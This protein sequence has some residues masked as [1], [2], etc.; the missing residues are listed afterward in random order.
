MIQTYNKNCLE[1]LNHMEDKSVDLIVTDP[2]YDIETRGGGI[3]KGK[4]Q[5][6]YNTITPIASGYDSRIIPELVRVLK[7][8]NLYIFCSHAQLLPTIDTFV[9]KYG[10]KYTLISWHKTN[11]IPTC[12]NTYLKDTEYCLFLRE[13]GVK[14]NG[15]YGTKSTYYITGI[16]QTD[17]NKW[18]HPTIKPL[19]IIQNFVINSSNEG[20]V[21]LDPFM[22]SGTTGVA[23]VN[24][25]RSFIG[26]EI[27]EAYYQIAL[28]RIADAERDKLERFNFNYE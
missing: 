21:I 8:I 15:N 18:K 5:R 27:D 9:N 10:C 16:N 19:R 2:P 22:G 3:V 11:P 28:K 1:V 12:N 14:V 13:S 25:G 20:D 26:M 23:C 6:N 17:K 4:R 7:R 24:L